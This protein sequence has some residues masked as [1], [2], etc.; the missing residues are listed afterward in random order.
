MRKR[1]ATEKEVLMRL[2]D[3]LGVGWETVDGEVRIRSEHPPMG[4]LL[5]RVQQLEYEERRRKAA[6][7]V[8]PRGDR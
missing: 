5:F 6:E 3:F 4:T 2:C 8:V 1:K 7:V